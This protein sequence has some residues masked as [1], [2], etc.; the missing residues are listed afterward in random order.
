MGTRAKRTAAALAGGVLFLTLVGTA[1]AQDT[2]C[3]V[4]LSSMPTDHTNEAPVFTGIDHDNR[5]FTLTRNPETGAWA[6]WVISEFTEQSGGLAVGRPCPVVAGSDSKMLNGIMP[7]I[8]AAAPAAEGSSPSQTVAVAPAAEIAETFRVTD[9]DDGEVLDLRSGA[10]TDFAS[11]VEMPA[12]ASGIAVGA[13]K[14]V[15]GYRF[16]WCEVTWQGTQGW[17]SACCLESERD[18]RRL[19]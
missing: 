17:A 18:G 15:D 14:P 8:A 1:Q 5:A 12:D 4:P 13:C 11:L 7:E 2:G 9:V 16:P 3:G 10:G 19:D 6:L